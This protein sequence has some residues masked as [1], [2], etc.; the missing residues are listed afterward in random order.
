MWRSS[1]TAAPRRGGTDRDAPRTALREMRDR[2][3]GTGAVACNS[4]LLPGA[5]RPFRFRFGPQ[6]GGH[7]LYPVLGAREGVAGVSGP[8]ARV[9]TAPQPL[10]SESGRFAVKSV[11]VSPPWGGI[12]L[13]RTL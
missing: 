11:F 4:C 8:V 10:P 12:A 6:F 9:F 1:P 2:R 7:G 3:A 13:G 5:S